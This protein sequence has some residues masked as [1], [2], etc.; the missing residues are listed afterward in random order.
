MRPRTAFR[1]AVSLLTVLAR[2]IGCGSGSGAEFDLAV[3]AAVL[4]REAFERTPTATA[5]QATRNDGLPQ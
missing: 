3:G 2:C 4:N 5:R 1:C